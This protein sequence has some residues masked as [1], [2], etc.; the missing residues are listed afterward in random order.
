MP[1]LIKIIEVFH[2]CQV[3]AFGMTYLAHVHGIMMDK[4]TTLKFKIS[5]FT[6]MLH[7]EK[8]M[9]LY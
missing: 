5:A 9:L 7:F 8:K 4:M 1:V 3:G 6:E 2:F